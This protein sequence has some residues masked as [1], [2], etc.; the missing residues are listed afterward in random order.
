MHTK[1]YINE[2]TGEQV[3]QTWVNNLRRWAQNEVANHTLNSLTPLIPEMRPR[4]N[5]NPITSTPR[6]RV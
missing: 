1:I 6:A 3:D 2:Q 5:S 4:A